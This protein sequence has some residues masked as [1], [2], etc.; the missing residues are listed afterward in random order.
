[1]AAQD[2]RLILT[3]NLR[4]LCADGPNCLNIDKGVNLYTNKG[5]E[6]SRLETG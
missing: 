2:K 5:N 1:M 3:K 6:Y 4:K